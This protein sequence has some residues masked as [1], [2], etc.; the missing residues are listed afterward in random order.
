[1][2]VR[3]FG[4]AEPSSEVPDA[5]NIIVTSK[6]GEKVLQVKPLVTSILDVS[7]GVRKQKMPAI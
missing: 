5:V 6:S 1:M 2:L 3:P 7:G 4:T